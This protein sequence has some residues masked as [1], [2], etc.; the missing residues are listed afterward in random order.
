MLG[1]TKSIVE[2]IK[3][4]KKD[5]AIILLKPLGKIINKY[6]CYKE[7]NTAKTEEILQKYEEVVKDILNKSDL[8][9]ASSELPDANLCLFLVSLGYMKVYDTDKSLL[10]KVFGFIVELMDAGKINLQLLVSCLSLLVLKEIKQSPNRDEV[11]EEIGNITDDEKQIG[12]VDT[13]LKKIYYLF[14]R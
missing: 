12:I 4:L 14:D 1:D 5:Q 6:R 2:K 8:L 10:K 11:M 3:S 13:F 9:V 7:F